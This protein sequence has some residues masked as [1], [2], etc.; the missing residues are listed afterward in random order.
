MRSD[1]CRRWTRAASPTGPGS[2]T[3][4]P[5]CHRAGAG[6]ADHRHRGRRSFSG[7]LPAIGVLQSIRFTRVQVAAANTVRC[8]SPP[9][10][11]IT[12]GCLFEHWWEPTAR[13]ALNTRVI[14]VAPGF[15]GPG[16][17]GA[18]LGSFPVPCACTFRGLARPATRWVRGWWT[19]SWS[20]WRA[21][22]SRTRRGRSRLTGR[23]WSRLWGRI[24]WR[25]PPRTC[26]ISWPISG[27]TGR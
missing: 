14:R 17:E 1:T 16:W 20:S 25:S 12:D 13:R 8:I 6:R 19:G 22:A 21:G 11:P 23:R 24:R 4:P 18:E 10:C 7:R 5:S 2:A 3:V 9:R 26:S 27:A 15:G